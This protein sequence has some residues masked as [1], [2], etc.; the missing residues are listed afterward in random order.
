MKQGNVISLSVILILAASGYVNAGN[1][2]QAND[3]G[4]AFADSMNSST[5]KDIGKNVDPATVPNYQGSNVPETSYYNSG[6]NIENQAQTEAASNPTAQYINNART[7]RPQISID[8]N[9]DPLFLR[10]EEITDKSNNLSETYSGCVELPVGDKDVTKYEDK[11]C[12]IQ[13]KQDLVKFSC[14]RNLD[15]SCSN[16]N[17]GQP[18]PF[19]DDD[20]KRSGDAGMSWGSSGDR[21]WY[22]ST[23]NNRS[24]KCTGGQWYINTIKFY[25][26]DLK[27]VPEFIVEDVAYDDWLFL[28]INYNTFF[29]GIGS[30]AYPGFLSN[31]FPG[32]YNCEQRGVH[33][34]T[35]NLDIKPKLRTGWNT[36]MIYHKVGGGGNAFVRFRAKRIFGC[37]QKS[38]Y[39]NI[40]PSGETHTK[41]TLKNSTCIS[42]YAT[43]YLKGYFPVTRSCWSWK[44]DYERLTDPYFIKDSMCGQLEAQGCGQKSASCTNHNGAFCESQTVTYSCPYQTSA[45]HVSMCGSQLVCPNGNCTSEFGQT[46]EPATEDFKEAATGLAVA[47]E[48]AKDMDHTNLTVFTG[49]NK[50]CKKK[51]FGLANCCKDSGWGVDVGL[52][53]CSGEEKE[54]GLM[55]E[56]KRTHYVGRYCDDDDPVLG[57]LSRKYVYCTYPSKLSRIII[58]QG[59]SQLGLGFGSTRNPNCAGF[60]LAELEALDFDSMDLSEFYSDVMHNAANGSTP[61]SNGVVQDIQN[62]I[63]S[64]YPE[65]Q[66]GN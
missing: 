21:F 46:Y 65:I 8:R 33:R 40:C 20:F 28:Y 55:K 25:I 4:K 26:S 49:A 51:S 36:M 27:T 5:V 2:T 11:T 14:T 22:G 43:K 66:G 63:N 47:E 6:L 30:T 10:H 1:T 32:T 45:R 50:S 35:I 54:L 29:Q 34:K 52:A 7:N 57:C 16:A 37:S 12:N 42:G 18:N 38:T 59:K 61:S 58:E 62:K 23:R 41:G 53:S 15:V 60:S 9:T 17:A 39:T 44:N 48:I 3:A 13:G 64:R 19:K 56:A 31:K 24:E